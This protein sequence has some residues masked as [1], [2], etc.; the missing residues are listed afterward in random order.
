MTKPEWKRDEGGLLWLTDGAVCACVGTSAQW[1]SEMA[2]GCL[3]EVPTKP[4]RWEVLIGDDEFGADFAD[5]VEEAR[6]AAEECFEVACSG[7]RSG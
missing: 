2:G 5:T 7:E 3:H 4:W 1:A 6:T